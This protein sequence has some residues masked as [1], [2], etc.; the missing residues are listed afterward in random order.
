MANTI[1]KPG[2]I[3]SAGLGVLERQIVLPGLISSDASQYF[4]AQSPQ[5]DTVSIRVDGRT[6]ARDFQWRGAGAGDSTV[7]MS[8][9]N[10]F[11]VDVKL[12]THP[13]NA[14]QLTDYELTLD[15]RDFTQQVI[16]PQ[17]RAVAERIED[18]IAGVI[19]GAT[20]STEGQVS[21]EN[22]KFYEAAV[23]ARK[24]LNDNN[25]PQDGRVFIVGTNVEAEILKSDQ[26][27]HANLSGDSTALRNATIGSVAG[28][29]V[30]VCNSIGA[31]EAYAY[32]RSAFQAAYRVPQAALGGVD[33]ASGSYAGIA[34]RWLKD[35]DSSK[36]TNRSI[37]DTFFGVNVVEDPDDYTDP[38]STTSLKRAVKLTLAEGTENP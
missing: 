8:D 22:G 1:L 28:F 24:V 36:L 2:Q 5:N 12:D 29:Q 4:S 26:F 13:Y 14:V 11:K 19:S 27:K 6:V 35:Y 3:V 37:F 21:I 15:I 33:T 34:L 32:H 31:D 18:K 17:T 16:V 20:Y 30:V 9:L 7:T 25:V 10:E 38:E 23:D